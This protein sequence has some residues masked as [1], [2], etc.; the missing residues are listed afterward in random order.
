MSSLIGGA[1]L[2]YSQYTDFARTDY[3]G[4]AL[5]SLIDIIDYVKP[6]ALLGL[7]TIRVSAID[8][9]NE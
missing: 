7:S 6:T 9:T 1:I 8:V 2:I 4:P 5:T 3:K